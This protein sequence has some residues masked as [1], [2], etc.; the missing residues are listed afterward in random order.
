MSATYLSTLAN[1]AAT[2]LSIIIAFIAGYTIYL[3]QR[4]DYYREKINGLLQKL[5]ELIFEWSILQEPYIPAW[6]PPTSRY[7]E[8]LMKENWRDTPLEVLKQ[9]VGEVRKTFDKSREEENRIRSISGGKLTAGPAIYL[10]TEFTLSNLLN[11]IYREFP[12]PPGDYQLVHNIP[13]SMKAFVKHDFPRNRKELLEWFERFDKFFEVVSR[14]YLYDLR[15][16]LKHLSEI[17]K[18]SSREFLRSIRE[19]EKYFQQEPDWS[20]VKE[21]IRA[22][23]AKPAFYDRFFH[24]LFQ[25]KYIVDNVRDMIAKYDSYTYKRKFL[26][27]LCLLAIILTGIVLPLIMLYHGFFTAS[28]YVL[29]SMLTGIGFGV[30]SALVIWVIYKEISG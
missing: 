5:D 26:T 1:I 4:R 18:K 28:L 10:E 2:V 3:R 23:R 13:V 25:M 16:I 24:Y 11:A 17:Y 12:T 21:L 27:L 9:Y 19:A 22:Y 7:I 20:D 14:I 29:L 6:V 30:S 15:S 8:I